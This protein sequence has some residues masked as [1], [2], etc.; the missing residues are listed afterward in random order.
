[1]LRMLEQLPEK[2]KWKDD[3]DD[4]DGDDADHETKLEY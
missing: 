2:W 3:D 4:D 1:M